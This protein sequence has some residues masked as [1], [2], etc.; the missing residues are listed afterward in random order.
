MRLS[1]RRDIPAPHFASIVDH[2]EL[3]VC[4]SYEDTS[5][6]FMLHHCYLYSTVLPLDSTHSL[7][8]FACPAY[9]KW[10]F[11]LSSSG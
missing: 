3:S 1:E 5:S 4:D 8:T 7:A 9:R 2:E 10:C 6:N 11:H